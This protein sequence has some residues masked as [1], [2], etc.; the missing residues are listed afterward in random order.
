VCV[1]VC[2]YIYI[3]LTFNN[4]ITKDFVQRNTGI[5]YDTSKYICITCK[6]LGFFIYMFNR[7]PR[8]DD[9]TIFGH[10]G[11]LHFKFKIIIW[12]R[13]RYEARD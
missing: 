11:K 1:C 12:G 2:V 9:C 13:G 3:S 4:K 7:M 6:F 10:M 5:L 8:N